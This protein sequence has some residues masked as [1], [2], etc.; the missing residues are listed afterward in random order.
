MKPNEIPLT[1]GALKQIKEKAY[2]FG[3][4]TGDTFN[5]L[6]SLAST[7]L[8][9][10]SFIV[11]RTHLSLVQFMVNTLN[12]PVYATYSIDYHKHDLVEQISSLTSERVSPLSEMNLVHASR[13][14]N[15]WAPLAQYS[16]LFPATRYI[17]TQ[18]IKSVSRLVPQQTL[19]AKS[20]I[21]F[22]SAGSALDFNVPWDKI[23]RILRDRDYKVFV[24]IS[25]KDFYNDRTLNG[26]IPLSAN[27]SELMHIF[28]KSNN[29]CLVGV[30]SGIFDLARLSNVRAFII[31]H[32]TP[33][34]V[35]RNCRLGKTSSIFDFLELPLLDRP[36]GDQD[37]L[38]SWSLRDFLQ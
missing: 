28:Y 11:K 2:I 29:L 20:A 25:G 24:N 12:I 26:C 15:A 14:I 22:T 34:G 8:S 10:Y 7:N 13:F 16:E 35:F 4:G 31:Y 30:R 37:D 3:F 38:L 36:S 9:N 17:E 5:A 6:L 18:F 23:I 27:H 1:Q 33:D 19:P 32:P 21:L